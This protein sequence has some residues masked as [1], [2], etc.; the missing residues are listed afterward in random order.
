MLTTNSIIFKF[1]LG[2]VIS[3]H[4]RNPLSSACR[5]QL[6]KELALIF[7]SLKELGKIL[8]SPRFFPVLFAHP[9]IRQSTMIIIKH[10][11]IQQY[12]NGTRKTQRTKVKVPKSGT[13]A[14][15]EDGN[16]CYVGDAGNLRARLK[17]CCRYVLLE[18]TN[19]EYSLMSRQPGKHRVT[20]WKKK[21]SSTMHGKY[22]RY[23]VLTPKHHTTVNNGL[24]F[25]IR[26]IPSLR[27]S[28]QW[29]NH[30]WLASTTHIWACIWV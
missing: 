13:P 24:S 25:Q 15:M 5:G 27:H 2:E 17:Y 11:S 20:Q 28:K 14:N 10:N 23:T 21:P 4:H 22:S 9:S 16:D 6:L 30:E 1:Y 8:F 29:T 19:R 7:W 12:A 18:G 3:A 26:V